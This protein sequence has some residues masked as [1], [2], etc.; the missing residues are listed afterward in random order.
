MSR[1]LLAP[2]ARVDLF[3]IW[4]YNALEAGNPESK[5]ITE[6]RRDSLRQDRAKNSRSNRT[7]L[8]AQACMLENPSNAFIRT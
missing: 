4:N 1:F 8:T 2:E 3:S 5:Y 6:G 7:I